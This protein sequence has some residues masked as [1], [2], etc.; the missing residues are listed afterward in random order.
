[1]QYIISKGEVSTCELKKVTMPPNVIE[2]LEVNPQENTSDFKANNVPIVPSSNDGNY[3]LKVFQSSL[4]LLAHVLIGA[5]VGISV[6]FSLQ[7]G[8]PMGATRLHI[9]LCVL[10][11][12]ISFNFALIPKVISVIHHSINYY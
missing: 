12:S 11:V 10:G 5:T 8:L 4:N 3:G 1:M 7:N 9:L 6:L 2:P